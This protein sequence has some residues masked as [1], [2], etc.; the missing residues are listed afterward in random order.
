MQLFR[1]CFNEGVQLL[2]LI[3]KAADACRYLQTYGEWNRAAW[4]AKVRLNPAESSDVLKRWAEHLCSPQVNQKSKAILV[5]LSLGCFHKVGEMLHSMRYFDRAALFIEAC[6]KYGS[7]LTTASP[8]KFI[9]AAFVDYAKMLRSIG[10]KQGAVL[11]ASRAGEAGKEL[12][13]ELSQTEGMG[14]EREC[15]KKNLNKEDA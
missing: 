10:L 6:L 13:D 2:C 15:V 11:W 1:V 7:S 14:L 3:D 8:H 4:L 9:G 5:L 12:L